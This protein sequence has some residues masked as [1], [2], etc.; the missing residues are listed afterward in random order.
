[1]QTALPVDLLGR[2][3]NEIGVGS[4]ITAMG[5]SQAILHPTVGKGKAWG[6]YLTLTMLS[7]S[8]FLLRYII[9]II[10]VS[11]EPLRFTYMFNNGPRRT[12]F[13]G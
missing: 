1:M 11:F 7:L 9:I 6:R 4:L 12:I 2:K 8:Q 10:S 13:G 5:I 3:Y